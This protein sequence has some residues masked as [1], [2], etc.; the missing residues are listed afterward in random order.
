MTMRDRFGELWHYR[1]LLYFLAWRDVKV[2]YKQAALGAAWAIVQPF[3]TM[4]VF[5][6]FFGRLAGIPSDGVPYPLFSFCGL[7]AWSYFASTL[8]QA[9]NSLVVNSSLITKIYFPRVLLPASSAFSCLLDLAVALMFLAAM[10]IYYGLAPT[11]R[12]LYAPL[13]L[14]MMIALAMGISMLLAALNVRFRDV[15]HVI[16]FMIQLWL[17]V[18]P[19]I[20]PISF[21]PQ[22][23]RSLVAVNPMTGIVEGLRSAI[24]GGDISWSLVGI[25]AAISTAALVTGWVYFS[26]AE[27]SFADVV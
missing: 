26:K 19:I 15:K 27:R 18:T 13:L 10:M 16:P 23:L 9:G 12:L 17:F 7:A 2:R 22:R 5:T 24:L 21:L 20:Y 11:W 8:N 1:E 14:L 25:S 4:L 6:L 3:F